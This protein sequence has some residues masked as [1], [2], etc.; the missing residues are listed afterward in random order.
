VGKRI[1]DVGGRGET[2]DL[3]GT[4]RFS[5]AVACDRA[6]GRV[7]VREVSSHHTC[8]NFQD[9]QFELTFVSFVRRCRS[10]Y[11]ILAASALLRL[12]RS[13]PGLRSLQLFYRASSHQDLMIAARMTG[14]THWLG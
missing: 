6:L 10:R 3:L 13:V 11:S 4:S 8:S 9:L 2:D 5:S 12:A 14:Y 1:R 7:A